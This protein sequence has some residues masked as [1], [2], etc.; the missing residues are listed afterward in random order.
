VG[1]TKPVGGGESLVANAQVGFLF[2]TTASVTPSHGFW[3]FRWPW[4]AVIRQQDLP[5]QFQTSRRR[6]SPCR[7]PIRLTELGLQKLGPFSLKDITA[8]LGYSFQSIGITGLNGFTTF[9]IARLPRATR[10]PL[11]YPD[12]Y[13][14]SRWTTRLIREP[15]R[16]RVSALQFGGIG[17]GNEFIKGV[18]AFQVLLP[19][20]ESR[21]GNLRRVQGVTFGIGTNLANGTGGGIAL[22]ERFF[23]GGVGGRVTCAAINFI[24]WARSDD[25]QPERTPIS[26]QDMAAARIVAEQRDSPPDIAGLGIRA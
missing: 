8:G 10:R 26:V 17:G 7:R 25:F 21:R 11:N 24:R 3:I 9:Q 5:A 20:P 1:N 23:P 6:P 16:S 22:Y 4:S 19:V 2:R 15:A 13:A 14:A 12:R 18:A